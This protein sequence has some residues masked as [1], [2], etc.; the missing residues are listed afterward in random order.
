M[1][2]PSRMAP[3]TATV[4][5]WFNQRSPMRS[6]MKASPVHRHPTMPWLGHIAVCLVAGI[7]ANVLAG[8]LAAQGPAPRA[9]Q[10]V[11]ITPTDLHYKAVLSAEVFA[12]ESARLV[13]QVTGQVA[14]ILVSEGDLVEGDKVLVRIACPDL[15][16]DKQVADAMSAEAAAG[17]GVWANKATPNPPLAKG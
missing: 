6:W 7:T 8:N 14:E 4:V 1:M 11:R 12:L 10:A 15:E 3:N 16:A 5:F 2:A 9:V 13:P 17:V